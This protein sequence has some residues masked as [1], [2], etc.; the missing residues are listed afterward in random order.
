MQGAL[1]DHPPS[2]HMLKI[3]DISMTVTV[4]AAQLM[5]YVH[6]WTDVVTLAVLSLHS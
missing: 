5:D 3:P 4:T 2:L 6:A 1:I